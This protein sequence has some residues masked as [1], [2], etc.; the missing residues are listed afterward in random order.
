MA[1]AYQ[2]TGDTAYLDG[3]TE[4]MDYLLGANALSFSYVTGYGT[5]YAQHEHHRFWANQG[6]FP[7][8]PPGSLAGGP[9]ADPSEDTT[10]NNAIMDSGP[11]KRYVDMLEAFS[12]NEVAINWNAPLTWVAAYLDQ[13]SR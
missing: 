11:A 13:Q 8:P 4:S 6:N 10:R 12:T 9:N 7:P 1:L 2:F 5:A 3:V